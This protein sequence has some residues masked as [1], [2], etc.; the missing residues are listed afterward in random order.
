ML[1]IPQETSK[2]HSLDHSWE[3]CSNMGILNGTAKWYHPGAW[4]SG[5]IYQDYRF[6]L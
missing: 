3:T 6:N 5:N 4:Q 1:E 2:T